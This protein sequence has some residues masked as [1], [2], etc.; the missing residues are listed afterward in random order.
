MLQFLWLALRRWP[1]CSVDGIPPFIAHLTYIIVVTG[2]IVFVSLFSWH[3]I[4]QP[5]LRLRAVFEPNNQAG[6]RLTEGVHLPR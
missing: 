1:S 4:E 3:L 6:G 5:F 2:G